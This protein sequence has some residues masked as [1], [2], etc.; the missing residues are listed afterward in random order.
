MPSTLYEILEIPNA[1][2]DQGRSAA[3]LLAGEDPES[4]SGRTLYLQLYAGTKPEPHKGDRQAILR[5]RVK[6]IWKNTAGEYERYNMTDDPGERENLWNDTETPR[7]EL[8]EELKAFMDE[9]QTLAGR[10]KQEEGP[11]LP[12]MSEQDIESIE[13]LGYR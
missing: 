7:E 3:A 6:T 10:F 13:A 9:C 8:L 2:K 12:V 5:N 1:P 11:S 4:W